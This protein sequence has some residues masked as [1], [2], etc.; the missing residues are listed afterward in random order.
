MAYNCLHTGSDIETRLFNDDVATETSRAFYT[1]FN[2]DSLVLSVN[3]RTAPDACVLAE[4]QVCVNQK[5]SPFFK[6]G[7]FAHHIYTGF[8]PQTNEFGEVKT[9]ELI[10]S[11]PAQAYR[12]RVRLY[13]EAE[14]LLLGISATKT[15]FT[16]DQPTAEKLPEGERS[17]SVFPCSQ[18]VQNSPDKR[19][20]CSPV[21]VYMALKSLGFSV[22]LDTLLAR[23]FDQSA[24]IYGNWL[25]NTVG[26]SSFG[27][28]SFF[29]R[30]S[31]LREL[32]ELLTAHSL[33]IASIAFEKGEL[34]GAPLER[35][36]GHLVLVHGWKDGRVLVADPA[37]ET[38]PE[39]LRS[40]DAR[41]F[42]RAWL[43]NKKGASYIVRIK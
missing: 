7:L 25:F 16:F 40:Y 19:R 22:S 23:V 26:A 39:V 6:L 15:P 35:T 38:E 13:G 3:F 12:Y 28:Q 14:V 29:R 17:I 24:G 18:M 9:D 1:P 36:D 20:I 2:F 30:F 27:A 31:S 33:V 34:T 4:V 8:P 42:A 10:L 11:Q 37:A 21:S 43:K 41:E 5:W 32:G